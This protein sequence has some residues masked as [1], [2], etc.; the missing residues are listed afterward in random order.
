MAYALSRLKM[1]ED[2]EE[3]PDIVR[4]I[5]YPSKYLKKNSPRQWWTSQ[6]EAEDACYYNLRNEIR[7]L[8]R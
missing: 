4:L 6:N 2:N 1:E 8:Q 7:K 5:S 3:H